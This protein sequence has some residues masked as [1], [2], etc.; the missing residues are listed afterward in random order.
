MKV[1]LVEYAQQP[2]Y[3][4]PPYWGSTGNSI[5]VDPLVLFDVCLSLLS[6][7]LAHSQRHSLEQQVGSSW[8]LRYMQ[9]QVCTAYTWP[10]LLPTCIRIMPSPSACGDLCAARG[11]G[12]FH[13]IEVRNPAPCI[14][15]TG[16][17]WH[18]WKRVVLQN[19]SDETLP[20]S[21]VSKE[22]TTTWHHRPSIGFCG[23]FIALR[24]HFPTI[25]GNKQRH[26]T[27]ETE[28]VLDLGMSLGICLICRTELSITA[29]VTFWLPVIPR[30]AYSC[31]VEA[32][33]GGFL[34][35][36]T[37]TCLPFH[38]QNDL[39]VLHIKVWQENIFHLVLKQGHI[40]PAQIFRWSLYLQTGFGT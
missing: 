3:P 15:N 2:W 17:G 19:G 40:V 7:A 20:Q 5:A 25:H 6:L 13:S 26:G 10:S 33:A 36:F 30:T 39:P 32:H 8:E 18:V 21:A 11:M 9:C 12:R 28:Q 22:N 4:Y 37:P 38:W 14:H 31:Q 29:A 24:I 1:V 34:S 23:Q 35:L 16:D 27:L